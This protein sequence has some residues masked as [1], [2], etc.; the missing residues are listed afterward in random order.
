MN[1]IPKELE[2]Q[3]VQKYIKLRSIRKVSKALNVSN[4]AVSRV[5][6]QSKELIK[7]SHRHYAVA[8]PNIQKVTNTRGLVKGQK[9]GIFHCW[10]ETGPINLY[11]AYTDP[12]RTKLEREARL[13][14][15]KHT[16]DTFKFKEFHNLGEKAPYWIVDGDG[17]KAKL[18]TKTC[19]ISIKLKGKDP[20]VLMER[21]NDLILNRAS[22]I[23][24][25][26]GSLFRVNIGAGTPYMRFGTSSSEFGILTPEV[27][28]RLKEAG[29]RCWDGG[30]NRVYID[31]TPGKGVEAS[32]M[33]SSQKIKQID[34][35][36]DW[37]FEKGVGSIA[38]KE[39]VAN[40]LVKV[41]VV[42][43]QQQYLNSKKDNENLNNYIG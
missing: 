32:G 16:G 35:W 23:H 26:F 27:H 14:K 7:I 43:P 41:G 22:E 31:K 19:T 38:T 18:T 6:K 8:N 36:F 40:A 25:Y 9:E 21:A 30:F 42:T 28:K 33:E 39:D 24:R 17:W 5:L 34:E 11:S 3:I 12:M 29:W 2:H 4:N 10:V 20:L 37:L 15:L 1:K 13:R